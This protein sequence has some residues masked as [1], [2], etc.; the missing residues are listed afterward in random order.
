MTNLLNKVFIIGVFLFMVV[1]LE[2]CKKP[3]KVDSDGIIS[4][5][6]VEILSSAGDS[7]DGFGYRSMPTFFN[8][9]EMKINDSEKMKFIILGPRK[10]KGDDVYVDL[11]GTLQFEL[12]GEPVNYTVSIPTDAKNELSNEVYFM[13]C[14]SS[15]ESWFRMQCPEYNCRG[16]NWQLLGKSLQQIND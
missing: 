12:N 1:L 11:L 15:I 3:V 6:S 2:A 16:F 10:N 9:G 8:I 5:Y 7:L 4:G 14:Q 13:N